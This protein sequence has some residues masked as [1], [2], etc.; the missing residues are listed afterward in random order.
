MG[1][2]AI[3]V[4]RDHPL[5]PRVTTYQFLDRLLK[6]CADTTRAACA[7]KHCK[8]RHHRA[9]APPMQWTLELEEIK[10][11]LVDFLNPSSLENLVVSSLQLKHPEVVWQHTS[12]PPPE[13]P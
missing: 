4:L 5:D 2:E 7:E 1:R 10:K 9:I 8:A 11:R 6:A 3:K 13:S 12:T